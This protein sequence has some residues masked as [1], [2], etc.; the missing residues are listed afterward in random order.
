MTKSCAVVAAGDLADDQEVALAEAIG[1]LAQRAAEVARLL[2][3]QV[4]HRVE[5]EA[6]AVA[7]RD[8]VLKQSTSADSVSPP[9]RARSFSAKKSVRLCS[10]C[11]SSSSPAPERARAGARVVPRR[12]QLDRQDAV[13]TIRRPP[14]PGAVLVLVAQ[15]RAPALAGPGRPAP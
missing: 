15:R 8:P 13:V 6:V 2:E 11:A 9:S 1:E 12:A 4:L 14:S 10:A 3:R 7:D 5:A